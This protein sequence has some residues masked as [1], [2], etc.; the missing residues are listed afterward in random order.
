M[1]KIELNKFKIE[2]NYNFKV[3]KR[4]K[5]NTQNTLYFNRNVEI[6]ITFIF[7]HERENDESAEKVQS[8]YQLMGLM[9]DLENT[10][11]IRKA[12]V[13]YKK[14]F[15]QIRFQNRILRLQKPVNKHIYFDDDDEAPKGPN[16]VSA[17]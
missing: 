9:Y 12:S 5:F 13:W 1:L 3:L 10:K 8:A 16:E 4:I 2:L 15:S 6:Y 11:K 7:R 17:K 14:R